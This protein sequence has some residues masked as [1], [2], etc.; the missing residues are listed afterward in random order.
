MADIAINNRPDSLSI[1]TVEGFTERIIKMNL[2][3]FSK[4]SI[5]LSLSSAVTIGFYQIIRRFTFL[6]VLFGMKNII[7]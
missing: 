7:K 5:I 2:N 3:I 4:F 1:F 6:R